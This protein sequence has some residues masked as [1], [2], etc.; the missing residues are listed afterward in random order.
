MIVILGTKTHLRHAATFQGNCPN[1]NLNQVDFE[2]QLYCDYTH[3]TFIPLFPV[4]RHGEIHCTHCNAYIEYVDLPQSSKS[5]VDAIA[6][7]KR[8]F[9]VWTFTG[10]AVILVVICLFLKNWYVKSHTDYPLEQLQKGDVVLYE[11]ENG[12][13]STFK[14]L[15][16]KGTTFQVLI[17]EYVQD[18]YFD[19]EDLDIPSNY[20][21]QKESLSLEDLNAMEENG[22]IEGI[23]KSNLNSY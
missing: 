9:P 14:I 21:K 22:R 1:C 20:G 5:K 16:R 13:Y 6:L 10:S 17:N 19:L 23:E 4:K 11:T 3:L 2:L 7:Q 8:N 12:Y 15:E 18:T